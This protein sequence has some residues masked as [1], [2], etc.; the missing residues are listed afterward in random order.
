MALRVIPCTEGKVPGIGKIGTFT[1]LE[2]AEHTARCV[3][4]IRARRKRE[5]TAELVTK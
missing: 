2:D 3:Q 5:G 4:A 1:F